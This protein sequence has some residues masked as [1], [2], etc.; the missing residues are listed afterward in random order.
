MKFRRLQAFKDD[1]AL[2]PADIQERTRKQFELF[3]N[4]PFHPSLRLKKMKGHGAIWEGHISEGYVFTMQWDEDPETGEPI[5]TFRR[6]GKHS[7]YKKP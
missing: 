6:I 4:D 2:L 7:I 1:F 5:A 3:R